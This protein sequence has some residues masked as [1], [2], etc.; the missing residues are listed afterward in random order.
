MPGP[1][2]PGL[3]LVKRLARQPDGRAS[4]WV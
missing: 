3:H 4:L 1:N 2:G